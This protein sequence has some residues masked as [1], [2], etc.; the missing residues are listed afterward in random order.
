MSSR[1][2]G[3]YGYDADAEEDM[4]CPADAAAMR[5]RCDADDAAWL[6]SDTRP[7]P[8]LEALTP[9]KDTMAEGRE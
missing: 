9:G 8:V 3:Y 1:R 7:M 4:V 6:T 5:E 2:T